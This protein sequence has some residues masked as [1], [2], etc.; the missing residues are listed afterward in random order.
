MTRSLARFA[1]ALALAAMIF[2]V[3]ETVSAFSCVPGMDRT[4]VMET[5]SADVAGAQAHAGMPGTPAPEE[6]G[7]DERPDCPF[8]PV[9]SS[10]AC[11]GA[12]PL[13]A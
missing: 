8:G 11:T 12:A 10:Q 4:M 13:P 7:A 5:A 2:A 1:G 9:A 6:S 3:A